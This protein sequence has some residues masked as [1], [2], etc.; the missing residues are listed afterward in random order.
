MAIL[1]ITI[2]GEPVLHRAAQPVTEF[3]AALRA[4]VADMFETMEAA[5]G[6]GLAAPQ[7][8]LGLRL[9]VYDWTNPRDGRTIRGV[10]ANPELWLSPVVPFDVQELDERAETEGCLSVPDEAYPLRRAHRVLLRAQDEHGEPYELEFE[11]WA[12]R[13]MQHE[14]DHLDGVIY[15]NRL[16]FM[17]HRKALKEIARLGFKGGT[18]TP[19]PVDAAEGAAAG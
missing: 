8:G 12:A 10:A 13:I 7:I 17:T 15:I 5:P 3:D 16:D 11:G 6:V 18:W 1:P 14:F 9:F 19:A 2:W 4:L